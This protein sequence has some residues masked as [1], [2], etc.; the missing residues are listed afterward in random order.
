MGWR[1]RVATQRLGHV[2]TPEADDAGTGVLDD[3][4]PATT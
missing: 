2:E 3:R 4:E 1:S